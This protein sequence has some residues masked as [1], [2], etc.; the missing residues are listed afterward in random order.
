M[1]TKRLL[2][3]ENLIYQGKSK[4]VYDIKAGEFA[5]KYAFLFTDRATG[6]VDKDGQVVYD[7][8][9]DNVVG[10]ISG[11]GAIA[12]QFAS[13]FFKCLKEK[14]VPSHYIATVGENVM[15]VEPATPISMPCQSPEFRGAA[16]LVNLE[17]TW[18]NNAMGS[19]WRRYPFVRPCVN[20]HQVV[21]AWTKGASD[22]L[23][24]FEALEAAGVMTG[25]EIDHVKRLVQAIA[26]VVSDELTA[27]GMHAIDGKFELGRLKSGDGKIV[28]IDEI[29]PD[30][31]RV[32]R[33][34]IPGAGGHCQ[35]YHECIVTE[36]R[37]GK[38]TIRGKK[39]LDSDALKEA[40]LS[41]ESA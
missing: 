37:E 1:D 10:E 34:Y 28:L 35:A 29:S 13:R 3:K 24:T 4:N 41:S 7:P 15:I 17:F 39:Q 23:I 22:I 26:Q 40:F 18:R 33:G 31:L 5:G 6:Y 21:E 27:R 38:R 11:K 25:S 8:G 9:Y 14:G 30:V 12:C 36:Y 2:K 20:L 19:F 32:C 16:P